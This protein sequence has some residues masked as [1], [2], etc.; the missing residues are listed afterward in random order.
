MGKKV[1]NP[2]SP[3]FWSHEEHARFLEALEKCGH[4]SPTSAVWSM[5]ADHVG[6]RNYKDVQLHANRYFLQLQMINTQKRK[7]MQTMQAVDSKWTQSEDALFE[8][9]LATYAGSAY[10]PWDVIAAR[11][12]NKS[13]KAVRERYQKLIYDIGHIENGHHITMHLRSV[14]RK[15]NFDDSLDNDPRYT[16]YDCSTTL[17]LDEEDL[18]MGALEETKIPNMMNESNIAIVASAIA[19]I[20]NHANK[21]LPTRE[22]S[23]FTKEEAKCAITKALMNDSLNTGIVLE[24]LLSTLRF[25]DL[26]G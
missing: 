25:I 15:P 22:Q 8:E 6:S 20:T 11:F 9:L 24:C 10:Y 4:C 17:T 7:E 2:I 3:H 19:A 5:I 23:K 12:A 16:M 14:S 21:N 26:D 18:L 13:A 1:F